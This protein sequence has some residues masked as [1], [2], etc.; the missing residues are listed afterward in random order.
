M[1]HLAARN[2]DLRAVNILYRY[3]ANPR[4]VNDDDE[5]PIT[6]TVIYLY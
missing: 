5:T 6:G 4:I 2:G 1:L 3:G